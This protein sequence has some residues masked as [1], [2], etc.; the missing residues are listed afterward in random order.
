MIKT[1]AAPLWPHS[2]I[3]QDKFIFRMLCQ[4][5]T[6]DFGWHTVDPVLHFRI[7]RTLQYRSLYDIFTYYRGVKYLAVNLSVP[8]Q[9]SMKRYE[10]RIGQI[11]DSKEYA[12]AVAQ[13]VEYMIQALMTAYNYGLPGIKKSEAINR[14]A[15]RTLEDSR[16]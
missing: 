11:G 7:Y 4:I 14:L 16:T 5:A 9:S 13:V 2:H 15:L 3:S 6:L 8:N 10:R 12:I 1:P